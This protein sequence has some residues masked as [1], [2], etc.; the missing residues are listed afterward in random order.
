MIEEDI[1]K[2]F[3]G[4]SKYNSYLE[5]LNKKHRVVAAKQEAGLTDLEMVV[6]HSYTD[7]LSDEVNKYLRDGKHRPQYTKEQLDTY[8][9]V[10]SR[11][12][13]K[14]PIKD[15][16][17]RVRRD[18]WLDP[19]LLEAFKKNINKKIKFEAF[20]SSTQHDHKVVDGKVN[21]R[22]EIKSLSGRDISIFSFYDRK[23]KEVLFDMDTVFVIKCVK[24]DPIQQMITVVILDEGMEE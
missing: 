7:V 18:V 23:E 5:K 12:I 8:A 21:C 11:A 3:I 2:I 14:L 9:N 10:L 6:I 1:V 15:G 20:T 24:V 19:N 13:K 22:M 16:E 4:I 17:S